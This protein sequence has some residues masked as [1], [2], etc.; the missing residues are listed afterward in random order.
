MLRILFGAAA[1]ALFAAEAF[2]CDGQTGKVIFEDKFTDDLGGWNFGENYGLLLKAP[3]ATFTVETSDGGIGRQRLN[4]T[5]TATGTVAICVGIDFGAISSVTRLPDHAARSIGRS[6]G[7]SARL[8][9]P[10][11]LRIAI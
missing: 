3:G 2:A 1:L 8:C 4:E 11:T 9:Q 10:S 6:E 5:F 7:F